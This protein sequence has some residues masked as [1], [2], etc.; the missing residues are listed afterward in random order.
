MA[1]EAKVLKIGIDFG[2]VLSIHDRNNNN[3]N[4][5]TDDK[6][7]QHRSTAL[8]MPHALEALENL[9]QS[10]L[11][12]VDKVEYS[13]ISFAGKTRAIET[14]DSLLKTTS[15]FDNL[16]FTKSKQNKKFVC[17]YLGG[18]IMIDDTLEILKDI[19]TSY[20]KAGTK[21]A[22]AKTNAPDPA[23]A[24]YLILF[25]G[26]PSYLENLECGESKEDDLS[27]IKNIG[28]ENIVKGEILQ[29]KD[30]HEIV[31]FVQKVS[32]TNLNKPSPSISLSKFIY[33]I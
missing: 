5:N 6:V 27:G 25:T 32:W 9:K 13:L 15:I 33:N 22:D 16:F 3:N 1:E 20:Q 17:Q 11:E 21:S 24:P 28:D 14:K 8:N 7:G 29:C 10:K 23:N 30:W 18:D 12:N 2:G 26:D 4:N 31:Q 19:A